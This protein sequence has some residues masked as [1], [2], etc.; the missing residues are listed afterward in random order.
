MPDACAQCDTR[1]EIGS[2]LCPRCFL[3]SGLSD[4]AE[5]NANCLGGVDNTSFRLADGEGTRYVV[6]AQLARSGMGSV[7]RVLDRDL[8]R[9]L[10]MKV[11]DYGP[12]EFAGECGS[13]RASE[14]AARFLQEAQVT[15]QLEHPSIVPV[16]ELGLDAIG[17]LYFTMKLVEGEELG[18]T[19][20]K[21][22]DATEGWSVPRAIGVIVKVCQAVAFAHARGVIHRDLKSANVMVGNFGEVYVMDWGLAQVRN[23]SDWQ[24]IRIAPSAGLTPPVGPE[25]MERAG[26][27]GAADALAVTRPGPER[28]LTTGV[29]IV[30]GTPAY[31][32]PEQ[33]EGRAVDEASDV[34][35]LG[36]I[37]YELLTG[38]PPYVDRGVGLS[39]RQ[40]LREL[41][42]GPPAPVARLNPRVA[43]ELAAICEKAMAREKSARHDS[44]LDLAEE[45]Q[46]WVDRRNAHCFL[47]GD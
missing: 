23:R 16:H 7:F 21:A 38:H 3:E 1:L 43:P 34:Y 32:S 47:R 35:S 14:R 46:A 24:D 13:M 31:M 39:S 44:A 6:E 27:S 33:A 15:A 45:L 22:R 18:R 26:E 4:A 17:R 11:L 41:R 29:G 20:E 2:T 40:V 8:N 42:V 36:A 25:L 19:F 30:L 12:D 9:R 28:P 10:A 37:L 5:L